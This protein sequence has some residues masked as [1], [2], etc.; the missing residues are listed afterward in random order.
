MRLAPSVLAVWML[1]VVTFQVTRAEDTRQPQSQPTQR[2]SV[3]C[4]WIDAKGAIVM[5][6]KLTLSEGQ[7]GTVADTAQS[8][9]VTGVTTVG[10]TH[11]SH[12]VVIQE[13]SIVEMTVAGRQP[14]GATVDVTVEQSK[15]GDVET[16][17]VGPDTSVQIPHVELHKKRVIDFVKFGESL[18][19]PSGERQAD[20]N[21]PRI[22]LV[23]GAGEELKIPSNWTSPTGHRAQNPGEARRNELLGALLMSGS[24][25]IRCQRVSRWEKCRGRT[26]YD[27]LGPLREVCDYAD[28]CCRLC[29]HRFGWAD[30]MQF[31]APAISDPA[32]VQR[33]EEMLLGYDWGYSVE[34]AESA[35]LLSNVHY[36]GRLPEVWNLTV[37]TK[38]CTY[39]LMH[40][41]TQ[42]NVLR[43][44]KLNEQ[45]ENREASK[46]DWLREQ[47]QLHHDR[48]GYAT[49]TLEAVATLYVDDAES[50]IP[51]LKAAGTVKRV[52]IVGECGRGCRAGGTNEV[53][54]AESSAK[55]GD[56]R[57]RLYGKTDVDR[58]RPARLTD[59]A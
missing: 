55:R 49:L 54:H 39:G 31:L 44:L 23:V 53:G 29:P 41:L 56:H 3:L 36:L 33:L 30:A 6:P 12:I 4:R 50:A 24:A 40:A 19:I 14:N 59:A 22:E 15:I 2:Y 58:S 26:L 11:E 1:L 52:L 5:A 42:V 27:E 45:Q 43:Y 47:W 8:P 7:K 57:L 35:S 21:M 20:G 9:F 28:L 18:A 51:A 34:L 17:K 25:K 48:P 38:H 10:K 46:E 16:K 13:G 37:N 32:Q